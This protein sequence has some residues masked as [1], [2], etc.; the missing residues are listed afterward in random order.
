MKHIFLVNPVAGNTD[1]SEHILAEA[2]ELS[3][4]LDFEHLFFIIEHEGYETEITEKLCN[5]YPSEKI[6]IYSCGGSGTLQRVLDA[7]KKFR[8]VEIACYPC[9]FTNDFL[10]CFKNPALF[11]NLKNL[12]N[13]TAITLDAAEFN[14]MRFCNAICIGATARVIG[15]IDNYSLFNKKYRNF[16]YFVSTVSDVFN[17][18]S[19]D[20][21]IDI[22]GK[23]YSGNYL[24]VGA[25]NG[26]YY[27]GTMTPAKNAKPNDKLLDFILFEGVKKRNTAKAIKAFASGDFEELGD[28]IKI[29][30][31]KKM[32][33]MQK[34]GL[35]MPCNVDGEIYSA[36][37]EA[38]IS[39]KPNGL[40]L[41]VP[42]GAELLP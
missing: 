18:H 7:S 1:K 3:R 19:Y 8:N 6:R 4:F 14:G 12:I 36:E 24:L 39:V 37:C 2:E 20:F 41:V 10:K 31:G 9:G 32:K 22:D 33:I 38:E 21:S 35:P 5:I 28:K 16:P 25:F 26:A 42:K 30:R 17:K 13:G 40:K 29:V 23:D 34:S 11:S 15:D 27:G